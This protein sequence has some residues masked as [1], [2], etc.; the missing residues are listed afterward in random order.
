[1]TK[2]WRLE[3]RWRHALWVYEFEDAHDAW[4]AWHYF[5]ERLRR[6]SL[7][8]IGRRGPVIWCKASD[9]PPL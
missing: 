1:M 3:R 2:P 5:S 4:A 9:N 7:H 6:G 8:L